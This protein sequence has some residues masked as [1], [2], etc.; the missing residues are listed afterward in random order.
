MAKQK[1]NS[2]QDSYDVVGVKPGIIVSGI[3]EIDLSKGDISIETIDK[4]YADGCPYL[5][6]KVSVADSPAT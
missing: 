2:W 1:N 4:L 3:G 6:K 5:V